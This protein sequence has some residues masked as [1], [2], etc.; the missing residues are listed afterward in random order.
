MLGLIQSCRKFAKGVV[1]SM[2]IVFARSKKE[3]TLFR[4][5]R[6]KLYSKDPYYVSTAEFTFD[7]LLNKETSFAKEIDI[8]PVM[9]LDDGEVLI[10]ALLIRDPRVDY[11]Q[12]SF[13]E[14]LEGI[15]AE[16]DDFMN[17]IKE[18]AKKSDLSKIIIGLNGHL[19][20]GVGLSTDM[21]SPNTFDSTYSK[22]YYNKYFENYTKHELIAFSNTPSAVLPDL[23]N[24]DCGI[25]I[26]NI[27]LNRFEEEMEIFREIC[28]DTI[29][30][31]FL[32]SEAKKGHFYD[33]LKPMLFFLKPEN[34]LFAEDNGKIVGFLFWHPDY[35][36][37]L[38]KGSI[39]ALFR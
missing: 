32:Y 9:A 34:I 18:F 5:F 22:L 13:F 7:M 17:H 10:T 31:T 23:P 35:N 21:H 15:E 14:A 2:Q 11:L 25:R 16:V 37:I 4:Q 1:G 12:I 33:L 28:N 19:S 38:K 8:Y 6:R 20:Y 36:E 29:G 26:R 24:R 27:D 30:T 39:T 3:I